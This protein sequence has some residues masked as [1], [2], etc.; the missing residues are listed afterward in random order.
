MEGRGEGLEADPGDQR[1]VVARHQA[2]PGVRVR[3]LVCGGGSGALKQFRVCGHRK[4]RLSGAS[5]APGVSFRLRSL[6]D[7]LACEQSSLREAD[8]AGGVLERA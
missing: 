7:D 1:S 3:C 6:G 8:K 2:S 4:P 5:A